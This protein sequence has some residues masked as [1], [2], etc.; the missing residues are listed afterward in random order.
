[1]SIL[2]RNL[3]KAIFPGISTDV[4]VHGGFA[5]AHEET[6]AQILAETKRLISSK[7]ATSVFLV[8]LST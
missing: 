6:A 2:Q 7:G 8:R 1:M 3:N 4:W 5:D